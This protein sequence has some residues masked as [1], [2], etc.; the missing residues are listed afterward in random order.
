MC[1][2]LL[3]LITNTDKLY[4]QK[5]K[6][7]TFCIYDVEKAIISAIILI[8]KNRAFFLQNINSAGKTSGT[9]QQD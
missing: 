5:L 1:R 9:C 4:T 6:T 8:K 3:E 2:V 7:L